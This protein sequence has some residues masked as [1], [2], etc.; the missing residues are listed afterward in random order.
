MIVEFEFRATGTRTFH[1]KKRPFWVASWVSLSGVPTGIR[2][3]AGG[4]TNLSANHYTI[5]TMLF[6]FLGKTMHLAVREEIIPEIN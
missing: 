2:T 4:S 5:G 1:T 3:L 6:F